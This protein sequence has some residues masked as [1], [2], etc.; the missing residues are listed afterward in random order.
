LSWQRDAFF[1]SRTMEP[2]Q[3]SPTSSWP[4]PSPEESDPLPPEQSPQ[5][6]YRSPGRASAGSRETP[7]KGYRDRS[8]APLSDR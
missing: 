6:L 4:P 3:V 7:S 5:C 1:Q 2:Q 8:A